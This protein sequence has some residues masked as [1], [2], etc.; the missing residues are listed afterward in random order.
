MQHL[1]GYPVRRLAVRRLATEAGDRSFSELTG[2]G[3]GGD[4]DFFDL[5][6]GAGAVRA[7]GGSVFD[8]LDDVQPFDDATED[9]MFG[10]SRREPIE[11]GIVDGVDEEL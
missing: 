11:I 2:S 8:V 1:W 4:G 3:F 9:R 6:G 10:G 5:H 7:I